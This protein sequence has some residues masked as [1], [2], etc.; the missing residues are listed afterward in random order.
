MRFVLSGRNNRRH[1]CGSTMGSWPAPNQ[2]S[3]RLDGIRPAPVISRLTR[4]RG[5][6]I[7]P[8]PRN[9]EVDATF[10]RD[11]EQGASLLLTAARARLRVAGH[12]RPQVR[13][14]APLEEELETSGLEQQRQRKDMERGKGPE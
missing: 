3:H 2:S 14:A 12:A 1:P 9:A 7:L 5:P 6:G 11:V 4:F 10:E 13:V 8:L